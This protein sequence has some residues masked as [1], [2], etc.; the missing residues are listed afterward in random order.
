MKNI[1]IIW[2]CKVTYYNVATM[3]FMFIA[4]YMF[5]SL[6]ISDEPKIISV[7]TERCRHIFCIFA[8]ARGRIFLSQ[9]KK[10]IYTQK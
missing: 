2:W 7:A 5:T 3:F 8:S 10:N 4:V 1:N 6:Q 9:A